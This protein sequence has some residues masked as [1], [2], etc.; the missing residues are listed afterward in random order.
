M[1]DIENATTK[2]FFLSNIDNLRDPVRNTRWRMLIPGEIWTAAGIIT[3]QGGVKFS[4]I[5]TVEAADDFALHIKTC[6]IHN[7][8]TMTAQHNYMGFPSFFPVNAKIDADFPF[9]AIL[10]EDMRAYE[11]VLG[12]HQACINTSLLERNDVDRT[13]STGLRLGLGHHKDNDDAN[14]A[15]VRNSTIKVE[16]YNW[17]NGD[18]ILTVKLHNAFPTA[19]NGFPLT[20][21]PDA[22]LVN[23]NFTLHCDRWSVVIPNSDYN[24]S[25]S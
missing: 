11:A 16:L 22:A 15:V 8:T 12:W 21:A 25:V 6:T 20:Y 14:R 13:N 18:I 10:L 7:I 4:E 1:A 24:A 19:I 9:D 23:F 17:T 5:G 2:T 3:S